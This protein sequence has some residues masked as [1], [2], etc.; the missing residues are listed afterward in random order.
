MTIAPPR[1]RPSQRRRRLPLLAGVLPI[2]LAGALVPAAA[3]AT[4]APAHGRQAH[5]PSFAATGSTLALQ[6]PASAG[7]PGY[8]VVIQRSPL[9]ITTQRGNATVLQTTDGIAGSSGP[10]DFHTAAG[11]ATATKV[12]RAVWHYGRLDLTLATSVAGDTI[13]YRI[14]PSAD[15]YRVSWSVHGSAPAD[16]VGTHYRIAASG[17]WYGQGEAQTDDGGP[18][19]KQPWPLDSGA[20]HDPAMAPAEYLMTDPFWFTQRG[21]GLWVDT[22]DV[23]DVSM[24]ALQPGV[25]GY[26]IT[27]QSAMTDTVFVERSARDVYQDYVGIAGKPAKSDATAT[28]YAKPLWNTWAQSYTA[29]SQASVLAYAKGLHAAGV[30]GHTIQIDDGWS[31]HYGDFDFNSKFPDPKGL[32]DQIHAMGYNFGLWVTLWINN[33][34]TN[35]AYAAQHGYLLKSTADPSKPCSVE[36]W[37][38][39]AGIVD[40]ANP[41]ARAWYVG[42]LQNL[43]KT[44]NVNGFK[45]DTRFFD[46]SCAPYPG[47]TALDYIKLGAQVTDEFDQQGAG[48]R[49]SWTGSQKYGFVIREVDKGTD[50]GSL[51]AGIVQAMAISTIGYP[52]VETDMIGGSMAEPPPTKSVLVRWAQA[53]SLMPLMYS[54]TSPLG[55]SNQAGSRTYDAQTAALYTA[56]VKLHEKLAPYIQAQ[57]AR[58]VRTGEPIMKPLFF[59]FPR[60]QASYSIRDEWLLG[61][62]LLAAPVLTDATSR[63]VHLPAGLWFD[64]LRH[65]IVYGGVT[66]SGYHAGLSQT[67]M[68][69]RLG[70]RTAAAL[71]HSLGRTG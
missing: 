32:S 1:C 55:V 70:T 6:V 66:L 61:D 23:M 33:D 59:D 7:A 40:L 31:T 14:T 36:W 60:D 67:P 64:V 44:Y 9:Q 15:R 28:E 53:A 8:R 4:P 57:V 69:I 46:E 20:V 10:V 21:S 2:L 11:W 37:N 13:A 47:Y 24:N 38:G 48:V 5:E 50:W 52:F 30:P 42:Q 65:R 63:D 49:L 27:G 58:A 34:A 12:Q 35:Y 43:E 45:F 51:Q 17:H 56:A 19:T 68:F 26:A 18:Y 29:V 3:D 39:T 16:Q 41:A 22:K 62:S 54:S 71:T 25:F